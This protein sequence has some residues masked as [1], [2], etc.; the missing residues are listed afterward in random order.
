MLNNNA[1]PISVYEYGNFFLRETV[2]GSLTL[3]G[4]SYTEPEP[5]I[6]IAGDYDVVY[7]HV[8]GELIPQNRDALIEQGV[9]INSP[10]MASLSDF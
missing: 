10:N 6:L 1:F 4:S 3:M 7:R 8:D 2:N 9:S 5:I